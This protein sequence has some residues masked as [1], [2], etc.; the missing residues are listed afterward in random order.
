MCQ[1][2]HFAF[3]CGK[4][5]RFAKKNI[6]G[7]NSR[8]FRKFFVPVILVNSCWRGLTEGK[9]FSS[10]GFQTS[11]LSSFCNIGKYLNS[12]VHFL[13]KNIAFVVLG[14]YHP[15]KIRHGQMAK[16]KC[17]NFKKID[18]NVGLKERSGPNVKFFSVEITSENTKKPKNWPKFCRIWKKR[19]NKCQWPINSCRLTFSPFFHLFFDFHIFT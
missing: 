9:N 2:N 19:S 3:V 5:F 14:T 13:K 4:I 12:H 17:E 7:L 10:S 6:Q 16:K 15:K 8:I 11:A 18:G 1:I